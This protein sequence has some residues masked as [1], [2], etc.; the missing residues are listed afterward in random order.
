MP[1]WERMR[2]IGICN[3]HYNKGEPCKTMSRKPLSSGKHV[4]RGMFSEN[5]HAPYV[6]LIG[7]TINIEVVE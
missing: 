5:N 4:I 6:P 3:F 2:R 1:D 7:T